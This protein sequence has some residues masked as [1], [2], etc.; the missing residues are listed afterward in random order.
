MEDI[1]RNFCLLIIYF[2]LRVTFDIIIIVLSGSV[3]FAEFL[4][5]NFLAQQ[6]FKEHLVL[7][8]VVLLPLCTAFHNNFSEHFASF[9]I[10]Q[11]LFF[12][13]WNSKRVY[14]CLRV[15]EILYS[16]GNT[17]C[18]KIDDLDVF[19]EQRKR[20]WVDCKK[21][22]KKVRKFHGAKYLYSI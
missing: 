3:A 8:E 22:Y 4:K 5:A 9:I 20:L 19:F 6:A 7:L 13:V 15:L 17:N 11:S 14:E 16:P 1:V 21:M 12:I 10:L 18:T 2:V